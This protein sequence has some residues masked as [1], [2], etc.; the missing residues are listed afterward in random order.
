MKNEIKSKIKSKS[1]MKSRGEIGIM[2]GRRSDR[3]G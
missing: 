2:R 3:Y 1:K